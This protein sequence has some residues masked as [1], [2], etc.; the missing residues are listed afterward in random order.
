MAAKYIREMQVTMTTS[1][2]NETTTVFVR[3]PGLQLAYN[4]LVP[5]ILGVIMFAMGCDITWAKI[6]PHMRRPLG[7]AI[8]VL[9]QFILLPLS[10]FGLAHALR[11]PREQAIGML[12]ISSCPGGAV[13]NIF[14]FWSNGDLSLR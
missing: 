2:Y 13:S 11:L 10:A 6:Y 12:V 5:A 3:N 14:T 8:G 9:C 4:I 1:N 7:P